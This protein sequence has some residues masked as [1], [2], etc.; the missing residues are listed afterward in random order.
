MTGENVWRT[1]PRGPSA[2]TLV[3]MA[4]TPLTLAALATAAVPG[5]DVLRADRLGSAGGDADVA[6]LTAR[7]G[8]TL[9]VR[10][11]RTPS[12]EQQQAAESVALRALSDG[13]RNRLPFAV[14]RILGDTIVSGT[15]AIVTDYL[16]G[17]PLQLQR[18]T[19]SHAASIG[20]AVAAVHALP[21]SIVGDIGLPQ[22]RPV[23]VVREAVTTLDRAAA[24]G[25]VP[26]SLLTRWEAATED[27]S[28]WQFTPTVINGSL[29][30]GA[31]LAVGDT[32]TGM[33][34]WSRLQVGDPARDLFW[35]LGSAD[36]AVPEA[37]L[38]A[39]TQSR[40]INDRSVGKRAVFAAELEVARWLLHGTEQR[41]T[42]IVDDAVE[43]LHALLDR[44]EG[45][46]MHPLAGS[47]DPERRSRSLTEAIEL[48]DGD[49]AERS[50]RSSGVSSVDEGRE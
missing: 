39:Y 13:V 6:R 41:S 34:G 40:G 1:T 17:T 7:D 12:G 50:V 5:L 46:V 45:D 44:V 24:T 25:L 38:D 21:T 22:W 32:V 11:P 36:P 4:R 35:I 27:H 2:P 49:V 37:A 20:Q 19:P 42:E 14:P 9:V 23:D 28:L 43:M 15:R 10:L 3:G 26:S 18:I 29:S 48:A 47:V 33:L 30:A 8:R 16:E 31:L